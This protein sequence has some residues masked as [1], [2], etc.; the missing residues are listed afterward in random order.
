MKILTA[1][2]VWY[3]VKVFNFIYATMTHTLFLEGINAPRGLQADDLASAE[4]SYTEGGLMV[5]RV[6][7]K[8][9]EIYNLHATKKNVAVVS[10]YVKI[11]RLDEN[12]EY[13]EFLHSVETLKLKPF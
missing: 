13:Q 8:S 4:I 1:N 12:L 5:L 11:Y 7:L 9:G 10:Q 3:S 6:T 2:L